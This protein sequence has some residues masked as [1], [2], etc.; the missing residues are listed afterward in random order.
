[1]KGA[2]TL[3]HTM[4]REEVSQKRI[5]LNYVETTEGKIEGDNQ[6]GRVVSSGQFSAYIHLFTTTI[7]ISSSYYN[8][9]RRQK[10]SIFSGCFFIFGSNHI[11]RSFFF[12]FSLRFQMAASLKP[13]HDGA[14]VLRT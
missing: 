1:M 8:L 6:I 4:R 5:K 11:P 10:L 9:L 2:V 7:L 3:N 13:L 12:D 14:T